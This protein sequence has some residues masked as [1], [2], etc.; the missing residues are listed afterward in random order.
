MSN[1]SWMLTAALVALGALA[2]CSSDGDPC[3]EKEGSVL[4]GY[5]AEDVVLSS[6]PN[7]GKCRYCSEGST[8]SG[9]VCGELKCVTQSTG[10]RTCACPQ[11]SSCDRCGGTYCKNNLCS[12]AAWCCPGGCSGCGCR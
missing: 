6:N 8:C 3:P 9:E 1:R 12:P 7:A 5:C 11:Y 10:C 4:C 2:A